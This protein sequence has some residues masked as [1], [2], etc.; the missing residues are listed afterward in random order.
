MRSMKTVALIV[1]GGK[2]LRFGGEVPKQFRTV[3]GRPVLSWA[4]DSFER[5][6]TIN[7]VVVVVSEEYMAYTSEKV[8]DP[9]HFAK[10]RKIV[11]G[12]ETRRQSVLNGLEGLPKG[13]DFVAI[14]DG[15][16][17]LVTP[18]D[19]DKV[20]Q[21]AHREK[22]AILAL[23][24]VDTVKRVK[25]SFIINTL[26]RDTLYLAQTPQVFQYDLIVQAHR[27]FDESGGGDTVT[28]DACLVEQR[29]F[30]V[31]AV[32]P[33]SPNFKITSVRDLLFAET[34]L[35]ERSRT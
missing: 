6:G 19:V 22:A 26:E 9:Y 12:G 27:G 10:V 24:A 4:I 8:V 20:V 2:S 18:E 21:V 33:T 3:C 17:P 1:A 25:N 28:D 16:R 5:A 13:T 32:E 23:K 14:H 11:A 30:K 34:V 7:E 35:S 31:K 29:G 15:A